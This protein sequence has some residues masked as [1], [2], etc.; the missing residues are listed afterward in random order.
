MGKLKKIDDI[1]YFLAQTEEERKI[2]KLK[3]DGVKKVFYL[4][5]F[6]KASPLEKFACD[7]ITKEFFTKINE[8]KEGSYG[9]NPIEGERKSKG[10]LDYQ[11]RGVQEIH[12][13]L[14]QYSCALLADEQGLGKT[15][16]IIKI[17]EDFLIPFELK[18]EDKKRFLI[19]CPAS[20]KL[21]WKKEISTW[22]SQGEIVQVIS[23]SKD[24]INKNA[25]IVIVNYDLLTKEHIFKQ[26]LKNEFFLC[27][28]DEA[29]Y[30]KNTK[31]ARTKAVVRITK[32]TKY[33]IALTGTPILNKPLEL[34]SLL[35][36]LHCTHIL[37]P[38][39][40]YR[41]YAYRYCAAYDGTWGFDASGASN[42]KELNERLRYTIMIRREKSAV[43][44]QLPDKHYQIIPLEAD[45]KA[46][47]IC[48]SLN[49]LDFE[50]LKEKPELGSVGEI[51]KLRQELALTKIDD[52]ISHIKDI[53]E[54]K[55]K[56][57]VF[58]HHKAIISKLAEELSEFCPVVFDGSTSM[59]DKNKAVESFQN[60][61]IC[62]VFIGQ[63][64]SA[65]VGITLTAAD[66]VVFV[67]SSW[68]PGE[69]EQ[70]VDRCHRI[71]QK[72]N[73]LAQFLTVS[74]SIDEIMLQAI[75]KKKTVIN[76]IMQ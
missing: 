72:N 24:W 49:K 3:W 41:K 69:V 75:V 70:A 9:D 19:I 8:N 23:S 15:I 74:G 17:I 29:H 39:N 65:G 40:N 73:V 4:D 58:A 60:D 67:E 14:N 61:P 48:D 21:N 12:K 66:T 37:K 57:V 7:D 53:L 28:F 32:N 44:S 54:D 59:T 6:T 47:A 30:L 52:C 64:Q 10:V 51:A 62:K 11:T 33:N 13:R 46:K 18:H 2:T 5:D 63:I 43:L 22:M 68:V 45:K 1:F 71:G 35:S 31:A 26:L 38:Y 36:C 50:K 27:V 16:Q 25:H 76:R 42:L 56:I 55:P 20:L 34:Y